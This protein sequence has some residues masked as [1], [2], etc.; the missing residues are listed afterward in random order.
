VN[1]P[2]DVRHVLVTGSSGRVGLGVVEELERHGIEVRRFDAEAGQDVR[3][4]E[5]LTEALHG[6][7]VLVHLAAIPADGIVPPLDTLAHNV[8]STYSALRAAHDV[9][10]RRV[11][12]MSSIQAL[13]VALDHR[14]PDYLPLDDDHPSYAVRPY[15]TSKLL[16]ERACE[17]FTAATGIPTICLR[18]P[19]VLRPAERGALADRDDLTDPT[20]NFGS[21]IDVRDLATAVR[22]A[23]TL[24]QD[25]HHVYLV[26]AQD[27]ASEAPPRDV[28]RRRYPAVP[29][30]DDPDDP[31]AGL[32]D[33][34]RAVEELGWRPQH[35]WRNG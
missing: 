30:R 15:A 18:P 1:S 3:D 22:C 34:S 19:L 6:C 21:W 11:V 10:V 26:A 32:I 2:D 33:I 4:T 24:P 9:G 7:D 31:Y 23:L 16:T 27:A 25:G 28:V 35:R 14:E 5:A 29:V 8:T 12:Y 13:G 17:S 20:W